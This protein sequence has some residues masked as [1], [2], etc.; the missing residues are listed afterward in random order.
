MTFT[1]RRERFRAILAGDQC[2]YYA[3]VY[4]PI[5]ARLAE[6][7]G[8]EVGI[9]PSAPAEA[10]LLAAPQLGL[11][12]LSE[13]AQHVGRTCRASSISLQI[14]AYGG[15]GNKLNVMRTVEELEHAGVS[16]L[17]IDDAVWPR[18]LESAGGHSLISLEEGVGKYK[19]ALAARQDPSLVIVARMRALRGRGIPE[20]IRRVKAYEK[21]G[22]D[23]I[24]PVGAI[25]HEMLEAVHAETKLPL[26]KGHSGLEEDRQY[27]A[28]NGVRMVSQGAHYTLLASAKAVYDTLKALRDGK[29]HIDVYDE[30]ASWEVLKQALRGPHVGGR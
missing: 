4:D 7:L 29:L 22:V 17:A 6:D 20:A 21:A 25:T 1:E 15:F 10:T 12:T 13:L 11:L 16:A 8:F 28:A 5:S 14:D 3:P 2:V 30:Q 9:M 19:A 27:L 18:D 23:A 24:T 26:V